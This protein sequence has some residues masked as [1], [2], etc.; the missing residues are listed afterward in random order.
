MDTALSNTNPLPRLAIVTPYLADANNGNWRTAERWKRLLAGRY[1]VIVQ[2]DWPGADSRDVDGVIAIHA[3]RSHT[4]ISRFRAA[5]PER[6]IILI[7][8]GTDLYRDLPADELARESLRLADAMVV[9]QDDALNHLP[10]AH[11]G[12][13]A[14]IYQSCR[15]RAS[16]DKAASRL[17]AVVVGHLRAEKSPQTIFDAVGLLPHDAPIRIDHIGNALDARL[18]HR[19]RALAR[20]SSQ[21]RYRGALPHGETRAAMQRAHVLIHPSTMEGGANV[22]GEAITAGTPVL[23]SRVSGNIGMLGRDY[24][25]Y[26]PVGDAA[27]LAQLLMR[28]HSEP[29]FARRLQAAASRRAAWFDPQ[30]ERTAI[31][32]LLDRLFHRTAATASKTGRRRRAS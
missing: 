21:Y 31:L 19:A 23:A 7:L 11:R 22:I 15:A 6:P 1:A 12:K 27:A 9:L 17:N 13:A 8:S 3:R 26:F 10:A 29:A 25:G 32:A 16:R 2:N 5:H 30:R 18:G 4:A 14:V 20:H 28:L 24:P